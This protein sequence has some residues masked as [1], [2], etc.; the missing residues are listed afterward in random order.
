MGLNSVQRASDG[1]I[2]KCLVTVWAYL[3]TAPLETPSPS[4]VI[5]AQ[6]TVCPF[7]QSLCSFSAGH[8]PFLAAARCVRTRRCSNPLISAHLPW[9]E[10]H[11]CHAPAT[12]L[13]SL[14]LLMHENLSF[15]LLTSV[16]AS[17]KCLHF[18]SSIIHRFSSTI[19]QHI[20]VL[21][22]N[23]SASLVEYS[24]LTPPV[25]TFQLRLYLSPMSICFKQI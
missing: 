1:F 20:P 24:H 19:C 13:L 7:C 3:E 9:T 14:L 10:L 21:G 5:Y 17:Q 25:P 8:S 11:S 16:R 18:L 12:R 2:L 22:H 23:P 15:L 6:P 4:P